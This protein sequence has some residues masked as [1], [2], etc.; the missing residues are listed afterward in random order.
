MR[1]HT[2][3]HKHKYMRNGMGDTLAAHAQVEKMEWNKVANDYDSRLQ[4][5]FTSDPPK[6]INITQP[7]VSFARKHCV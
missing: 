5:V 1:M 3:V 7:E 4:T 2:H 6:P